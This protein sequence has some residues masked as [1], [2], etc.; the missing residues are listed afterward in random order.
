MTDVVSFNQFNNITVSN[1]RKS[2]SSG[3]QIETIERHRHHRYAE[4]GDK[5]LY[6]SRTCIVLDKKIKYN[7]IRLTVKYEDETIDN[8][9]GDKNRYEII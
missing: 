6:N 2:V 3:P 7:T 8:I 4:I 1:S 5:I 9:S